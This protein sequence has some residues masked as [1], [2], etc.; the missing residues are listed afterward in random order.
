MNTTNASAEQ[1]LFYRSDGGSNSFTIIYDGDGNLIVAYNGGSWMAYVTAP[2]ANAWHHF[3]YTTQ[4]SGASGRSLYI[5]GV[6]TGTFPNYADP[7]FAIAS[8]DLGAYPTYYYPFDG[9]MD[10]LR[11]SKTARSRAWIATEYNNQN[12]PSGFFSEGSQQ[13]NSGSTVTIT[14]TSAPSGL[15]LSVN[16]TACTAPC[17]FQWTPGSNQTIAVSTSPQGGGTGTQY[18]YANW[19]DSGAQSHS[20]TVPSSAATYTA[21]FTT[22][23]YLTTS[24]NPSGEGTIRTPA[25][26]KL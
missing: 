9:S 11:V 2:S 20:I 4:D 26:K 13:T 24:V 12:S 16:G 21:N 14:V 19:S 23:Y 22:Q 17:S 18:A 5:D 6:S 25:K 15:S 1:F 8:Y 3:V 10:E 7:S